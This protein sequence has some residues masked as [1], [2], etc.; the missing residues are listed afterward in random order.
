MKTIEL[1]PTW[2]ALVP[3]LLAVIESGTAEGRSKAKAE[4]VDLAKRVDEIN[5]EIKKRATTPRGKKVQYLEAQGAYEAGVI[6][7]NGD[8]AALVTN[9][10]RVEWFKLNE[11]GGIQQL[12]VLPQLVAALDD[13]LSIDDW[14]DDLIANPQ[15]IANAQAV[16]ALGKDALK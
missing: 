8:K 10:G 14:H 11:F 1:K 13:M 5:E 12:A 6:L 15:T 9:E 16:L 7:R 3:V 2:Q 4:L